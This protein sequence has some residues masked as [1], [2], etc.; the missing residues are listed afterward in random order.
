MARPGS[1]A[2]KRLIEAGIALIAENGTK[3]L[4]VRKA[5]A[6]AG[7][8][9]GLFSYFFTNKDIYLK[10][11]F[12]NIYADA[13]KFVD[14]NQVQQFNELEQLKY[15][16]ERMTVYA[17]LRRNL[18]RAIFVECLIDEKMHDDY[19]QKNILKPVR[20][21]LQLIEKAQCAGYLRQDLTVTEIYRRLFFELIM[22]VLFS[23]SV[24]LLMLN[25]NIPEYNQSDSQ[26]CLVDLF[27]EL[28]VKKCQ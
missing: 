20:L 27:N 7:V 8:N 23:N 24:S 10:I 14:M 1:D 9:L 5:C 6:K 19:V 16:Y 17:F 4:T 12:D 28:E 2:D 21:P 15:F 25:K 18:I 3:A 22:P 11:I 13:E 26:K